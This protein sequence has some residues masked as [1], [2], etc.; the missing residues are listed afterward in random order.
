VLTK[1]STTVIGLTAA[2]VCAAATA[3]TPGPK[4]GKRFVALDT[5]R[6]GALS[7]M[8][9]CAGPR[10]AKAKICKNFAV[11]DAN[12][13]G[14]ISPAEMHEYGLAKRGYVRKS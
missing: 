6:D 5:N 13:D 3:Q 1:F 2:L 7:Q 11:I 9:A 10:G 12:H 14:A 4:V 8:E